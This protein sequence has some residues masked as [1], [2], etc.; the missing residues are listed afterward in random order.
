MFVGGYAK[1]TNKLVKLEDGPSMLVVF[2]TKL[3]Q[4]I[5]SF[6]IYL[7]TIT[8]A[9]KSEGIKN[10]FT[11]YNKSVKY[12]LASGKALKEDIASRFYVILSK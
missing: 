11:L 2:F 9:V 6:F 4:I 5:P 7:K 3:L 10:E 8:L 1:K 12:I